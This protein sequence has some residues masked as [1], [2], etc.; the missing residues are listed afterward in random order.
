MM[1]RA[2]LHSEDSRFDPKHVNRTPEG[3]LRRR[4]GIFDDERAS[5]TIGEHSSGL[6]AGSSNPTGANGGLI[7]FLDLFSRE[8]KRFHR[9]EREKFAVLDGLDG[10]D[11]LG[12][13]ST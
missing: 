5:S 2:R 9:N 8:R 7:L 12:P 10:L 11:G 3:H 4:E 6:F 1:E 13:A